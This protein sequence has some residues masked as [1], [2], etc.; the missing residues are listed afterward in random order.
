[1]G[2]TK[3]ELA[4]LLAARDKEAV[5][6]WCALQDPAMS[7]Y[8]SKQAVII[9]TKRIAAYAWSEYGVRANLVSPGPVETP[10]KDNLRPP[11]RDRIAPASSALASV[12]GS[13]ATL[14][15]GTIHGSG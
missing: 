8:T 5:E 11:A 2:A 10:I 12:N 15:A 6:R 4:G 14:A 1:M 7:C 3:D 9:F 13:N